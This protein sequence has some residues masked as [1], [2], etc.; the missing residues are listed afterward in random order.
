MHFGEQHYCFSANNDGRIF[1][2]EYIGFSEQFLR[3]SF[4]PELKDNYLS[5]EVFCFGTFELSILEALGV[6]LEIF[7]VIGRG[8]KC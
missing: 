2:E 8:G 3:V 5:D 1:L 6:L 4:V 7:V